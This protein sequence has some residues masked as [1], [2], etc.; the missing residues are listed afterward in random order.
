MCASGRADRYPSRSASRQQ[1][2]GV[3]ARIH[4]DALR[5]DDR[6]GMHALQ[7]VHDD[8]LAGLQAFLH[9]AQAVGQPADLHRR[10]T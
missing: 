4:R 7:A 2:L 9:D 5:R 3:L 8:V 6:A 1:R 10:D